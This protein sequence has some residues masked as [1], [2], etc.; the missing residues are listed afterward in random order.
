[1]TSA[2]EH[3]ELAA[4][5]PP[6]SREQWRELVAG[7]LAKAGKHPDGPAELELTTTTYDDIIVEPLYTKASGDG[8]DVAGLPG[9]PPFV[10]GANPEG[11]VSTGWDVRGGYADAD[12]AAVNEDLLADLENGVSSAWLA[13]GA[14]GVPVE[15][16]PDA[17][18]GVLL[19]LAPVVLSPGADYR[20]AG[21]ALGELY[22]ANQIPDSAV[23]AGFGVDPIALLSAGAEADIED[24]A[25]FAAGIAERYPAAR[26]VSVDA[27]PYHDAGGS[28]AQELGLSIAAGVAYLRALTAAGLDASTAAATME[29]RYAATADQFSTIAK[30]R[31]ARR[32]WSRVCEA[33]DAGEQPQRQH[34]VTSAAMMTERDPWVNMVRGTIACFGAGVGGADAVT[35]R[36]FDAAIGISDAFARRIARNTQSILLEESKLAGVIDPAGGSA[37]VETLTEQQAQRAWEV[38][39]G[40]ERSGGIVA[41]LASGA[42]AAQLARTWARRSEN[43]ARRHD[44]ITGVSEFP[45]LDEKPLTRKPLPATRATGGLPKRRYAA[46]YEQLRTRADRHLEAHGER[47]TAFLATLGPIAAHTARAAFARNLYAAGGIRSVDAGATESTAQVVEAFTA[48]GAKLACVCGADKAYAEQ[49]A[50]VVAALKEAGAGAVVVAGKPKDDGGADGLVY[51]G[52]DAIAALEEAFQTLE[53]A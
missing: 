29:F 37:Y 11:R 38:F 8:A 25:A 1:M 27:T 13:V 7:V 44:P 40:I 49:L 17:L 45:D 22:S 52:C 50:E 33:S 21:A 3:L 31:A 48:S 39:T 2:P 53:V 28:D 26:A 47:P 15:R 41:A 10:R 46:A 35:V 16:L 18:S 9:L 12:P 24:A 20:A 34:A 23:R 42:V 51:V 30:F 43:I 36:P 6:A 4:E 32:L 19:D 5:F 14:D